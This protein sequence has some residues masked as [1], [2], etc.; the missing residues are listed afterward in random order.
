[1]NKIFYPVLVILIAL[2][3]KK[4]SNNY[5]QTDLIN[6]EIK[7]IITESK[8]LFDWNAQ[9]TDFIFEA[10]QTCEDRCITVGYN[11]DFITSDKLLK[12]QIIKEAE[13]SE[14]LDRDKILLEENDKL[15][16]L[17]FS[18]KNKKTI[19]VLRNFDRVD[20]VEITNFKYDRKFFISDQEIR[21]G[22]QS[23]NYANQRITNVNPG[24]YDPDTS[25]ISY[26]KYIESIS[27]R[28]ADVIRNHNLNFVYDSLNKFDG[29]EVAVLDNGVFPDYVPF[30]KVGYPAYKT[31]GYFSPVVNGNPDGPHPRDYDLFGISQLING[32][33]DHGTRQ[34]SIV[35]SIIPKGKFRTVRSAQWVFFIF[36]QDFSGTIRAITAMADDPDVKV[37]SMSM[38]TIFVNNEMKR[39]IQYYTA[40]DKLFISAS[41][42]FLPVPIL[43]DLIGVIFP[44]SMPET[45]ATTGIKNTRT[46]NGV[47]ELGE[48]STSGRET[49]FVVDHSTSSSETVSATAAMFGLIWSINPNLSARQIKEIFICSST[50]FYTNNAQKHPVFGWGKVDCKLAAKITL[51]TL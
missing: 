30:V 42:T 20:F 10:L 19:D 11:T 4:E 33:F 29:L 13:K 46:T 44:A 23:D 51:E 38:G 12:E 49:D 25:S 45:I 17:K 15:S 8:T 5:K 48:T 35:Y 14:G 47:F 27:G 28:D 39:A 21:T 34:T 41:G 7:K 24:D 22:Y 37:I 2:S 50:Y 32:L 1:M 9:S 3:C 36:P 16:T 40:K 31:E 26:D 43:K 18:I 6:Q